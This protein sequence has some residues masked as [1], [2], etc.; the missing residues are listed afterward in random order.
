[1]TSE[2]VLAPR[3][4]VVRPVADTPPVRCRT[5]RL[6]LVDSEAIA[7]FG[8][9]QLFAADPELT[10]AGEAGT[11]RDAL[12]MADRCPPDLVVLDIDLG[13]GDGADLARMLLDRHK[14]V[15]V[16]VLTGSRDRELLQRQAEVLA[17]VAQL[18]PDGQ[19]D[20]LPPRADRLGGVRTGHGH[21][22]ASTLVLGPR[23]GASAATDR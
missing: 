2:A 23:R 22:V 20:G 16:L 21:H 12:L 8:L 4:P 15:R 13:R 7:R 6:L 9:R 19:H 14:G 17:R 3:S 18:R 11:A 1:V 5:A 10:V